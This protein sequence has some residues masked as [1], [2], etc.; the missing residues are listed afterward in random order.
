M[1][2]NRVVHSP[3]N[4]FEIPG[5]N[6]KLPECQA[7]IAAEQAAI[8]EGRR[9][10]GD[11]NTIGPKE[12]Q[13]FFF[14]VVAK[15]TPAENDSLVFDASSLLKTISFDSYADIVGLDDTGYTEYLKEP[16]LVLAGRPELTLVSAQSYDF[17]N[18]VDLFH[19]D[20]D[21]T[22]VSAT[23]DDLFRWE[24]DRT[25]YPDAAADEQAQVSDCPSATETAEAVTA[26]LFKRSA[27]TVTRCSADA[28]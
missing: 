13:R 10:I 11:P 18:D 7:S 26:M 5:F 17:G 23:W 20:L 2:P 4:D 19:Y 14:T 8:D 6:P 21:G 28:P 16:R 9:T 1:L 12:A 3:T 15:L 22:E 25:A 27:D 24:L